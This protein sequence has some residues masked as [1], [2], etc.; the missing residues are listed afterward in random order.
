MHT[1][2]AR[3]CVET[4]GP[5]YTV[6]VLSAGARPVYMRTVSASAGQRRVPAPGTLDPDPGNSAGYTDSLPSGEPISVSFGHVLVLLLFFL[7]FSI[8]R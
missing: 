1:A 4:L 6:N 7:F 2:C 3:V 5:V 8:P